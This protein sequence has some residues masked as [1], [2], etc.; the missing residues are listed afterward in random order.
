MIN[1]MLILFLFLCFD[2]DATQQ[3]TTRSGHTN[4]WMSTFVENL[5]ENR[6]VLFLIRDNIL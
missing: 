1:H 6:N 3:I 2:N 5:K 4:E